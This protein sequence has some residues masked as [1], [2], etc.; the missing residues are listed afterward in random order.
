MHQ[1][2]PYHGK[3]QK[4]YLAYLPEASRSKMSGPNLYKAVQ[5]QEPDACP[6]PDSHPRRAEVAV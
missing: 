2:I 3:L 6:L 4:A 5:E 1:D